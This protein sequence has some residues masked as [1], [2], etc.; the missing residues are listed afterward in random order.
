MRHT[1][2]T[3]EPAQALARL[4]TIRQNSL[5]GSRPF[6]DDWPQVADTILMKGIL[7]V[8]QRGRNLDAQQAA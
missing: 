4:R 6:H 5:I 8:T 7:D 2:Q 1:A 3:A